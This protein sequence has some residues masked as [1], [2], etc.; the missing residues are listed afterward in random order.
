MRYVFRE[1]LLV[2]V[3]ILIALQIKNLNNLVKNRLTTLQLRIDDIAQDDLNLVRF[4]KGSKTRLDVNIER[5][6]ENNY[7][8]ILKQPKVRN[9]LAMKLLLTVDVMEFRIDLQKEIDRI[10]ELIEIELGLSKQET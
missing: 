8:E 10:I 1:I 5:K 3:G 2:V 4:T 7:S 9:L 6:P